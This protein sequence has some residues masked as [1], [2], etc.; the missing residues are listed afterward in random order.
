[1]LELGHPSGV[2]L[3]GSFQG[4]NLLW[5]ILP[6]LFWVNQLGFYRLWSFSCPCLSVV[7][8]AVYVSGFKIWSVF[9]ELAIYMCAYSQDSDNRTRSASYPGARVAGRRGSATHGLHGAHAG[10]TNQVDSAADPAQLG[11]PGA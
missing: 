11:Y 9:V 4:D 3:R 2:M 6:S 5:Q 1:M 7:L 10:P 8:M